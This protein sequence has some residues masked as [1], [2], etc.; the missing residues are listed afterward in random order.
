MKIVFWKHRLARKLAACGLLI[1]SSLLAAPL[2][3]NLVVNPSFEEVDVDDIGPFTSVRAYDWE[4]FDGDEDDNFAYPYSSNYSGFPEPDNSGDYHY[5]GGFGTQPGSVQVF[6]TIDLSKEPSGT[7][8][9]T[10]NAF[11]SLNG[12][13]SRYQEQADASR[14]RAIFRNSGNQDLATADVGGIDFANS[15]FVTDGK[16]D[17]GQSSTAGRI[18]TGTTSVEIQI[19]SDVGTANHD[20]YVDLINF[21]VTDQVYFPVLNVEIDRDSRRLTL[22]NRTGQTVKLSGYSVLSEFEALNGVNWRSIA[23]NYDANSGGAVDP[24][25]VWTE[26]SPREIGGEL[27]EQTQTAGTEAT[28]AAGQTIDLGAA[29]WLASPTE[30]LEFQY[31]SKGASVLGVVNYVGN[32]GQPFALGD[33]SFDGKIDV[34]D[35]KLLRA[36][37][38]VAVTSGSAAEAYGL[39]DLNADLVNNHADFVTFQYLYDQANG[40]GAFEVMVNSVPEGSTG[41]LLLVGWGLVTVCATPVILRELH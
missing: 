22:A 12:F 21:Q 4:D 3:T 33:L 11:Y 34:S 26:L 19:V 30:D 24:T 14:V 2:N 18:P 8:I 41:L 13:F 23:G 38:H 6:Q 20:G 36:G 5:T 25:H 10:G 1:P 9:P 15:L 29:V 39:G 32:N 17:W 31:V 37:Q 27:K 7:L 16:T 40:A 35:W 28:L